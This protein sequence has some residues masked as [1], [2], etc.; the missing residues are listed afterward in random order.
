MIYKKKIRKIMPKRPA[1]AYAQFMKEKKVK[2]SLK[3]KPQANI[4]KKIMKNYQK[5]KRKNMKKK[6]KK[7]EKDMKKR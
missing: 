3:A 6:Q 2:K 1:N 5:I 4:G 7:I